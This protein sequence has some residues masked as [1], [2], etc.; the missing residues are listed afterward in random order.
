MLGTS[1]IILKY[2]LNSSDG[3]KYTVD[4]GFRIV[5]GFEVSWLTSLKTTLV[6]LD[7]FKIE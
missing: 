7:F 1:S 3:L 2:S 4:V 6:E 5:L